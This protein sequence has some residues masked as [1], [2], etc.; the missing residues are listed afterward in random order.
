M[1]VDKYP[2]AVAAATIGIIIFWPYVAKLT[3]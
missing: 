2:T 3:W 1:Q